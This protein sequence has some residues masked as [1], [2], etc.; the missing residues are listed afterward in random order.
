MCVT[1]NPGVD[2]SSWKWESRGW[3]KF[4]KWERKK[5]ELSRLIYV[6]RKHGRRNTRMLILNQQNLTAVELVECSMWLWICSRLYLYWL[7]VILLAAVWWGDKWSRITRWLYHTRTRVLRRRL[8]KGRRRS[9]YPY[10]TKITAKSSLRWQGP[11][12]AGRHGLLRCSDWPKIITLMLHSHCIKFWNSSRPRAVHDSPDT[13]PARILLIP[14]AHGFSWYR[15]LKGYRA[16]TE[17]STASTSQEEKEA[18]LAGKKKI[19]DQKNVSKRR[20]YHHPPHDRKQRIYWVNIVRV[21]CLAAPQRVAL[22]VTTR[23]RPR[24]TRHGLPEGRG[25]AQLPPSWQAGK[26]V[27]VSYV[28]F[29][30]VDGALFYVPTN[31]VYLKSVDSSRHIVRIIIFSQGGSHR[32][33]RGG[34]AAYGTEWK[35]KVKVEIPITFKRKWLRKPWEISLVFFS[36]APLLNNCA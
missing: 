8:S 36:Q 27:H 7:D 13:V 3:R 6:G 12:N 29:G 22:T 20:S 23:T 32:S 31:H 35:Q 2:T 16:L 9:K 14:C 24:Q 34:V 5:R 10:T 26:Y 25:A 4:M 1:W 28:S 19:D 21:C 30:R 15:A 11:I 17:T 18:A 33:A